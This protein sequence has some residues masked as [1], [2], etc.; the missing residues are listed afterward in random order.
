MT[1]YNDSAA[2]FSSSHP[3]IVPGQA[4]RS[5]LGTAAT[6]NATNLETG[7]VALEE[8]STA[9]G[10][11]VSLLGKPVVAL[12]PALRKEGHEITQSVLDPST[13]NN[14]INYYRNGAQLDMVVSTHLS[15]SFGGSNTAWFLTIPQRAQ[16]CHITRQAPRLEQDVN[17][18]NKVVTFTIDARWSD[19]AKHWIRTWG[20][21][22]A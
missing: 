3:S 2:L 8:Q 5:N 6:F 7:L 18:K 16:L 17:I 11:P 10:L 22:G 4:N 15:G 9:D 13:A 14:S 12:P 20:N 21:Q 19:V 1:W